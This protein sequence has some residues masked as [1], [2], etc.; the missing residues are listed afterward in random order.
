M[1]SKNNNK[2]IR[3]LSIFIDI[4]T[5]T[6]HGPEDLMKRFDI[7]RRMLQRDLKDLKDAGIIRLK[8]DRKDKNYI[9]D[10]KPAVFDETSKGRHRQHLIRLRRL[11]ILYDRLPR[12]PI[13]DIEKYES[14]YQEYLDYKEY[15]AEDPETFPPEDL[16]KPPQKPVWEDIR[17][18]YYKLFPDSS[19]RM[20]QRDFNA[21]NDAGLD[22][23]YN[24]RYRNFIFDDGSDL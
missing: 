4:S 15:M 17:A 11:C 8:L 24:R 23:S 1:A 6:Y 5:T 9:E 21:L 3:Q 2:I 19:E 7:S 18:A 20:R 22:I 10:E 13:Y 14:E 16:G 12:S